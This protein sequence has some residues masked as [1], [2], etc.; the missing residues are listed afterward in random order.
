MLHWFRKARG[1]LA[2]DRL[3][4]GVE[5]GTIGGSKQQ[6]DAELRA[7]IRVRLSD[8]DNALD[9][10]RQ[11]INDI[12]AIEVIDDPLGMNHE[13]VPYEAL[14]VVGRRKLA[15]G[16]LEVLPR[17]FDPLSYRRVA[18]EVDHVSGSGRSSVLFGDLLETG[19]GGDA[20][21]I[22]V[23][24]GNGK[25]LIARRPGAL[26]TS[27]HRLPM[28][29]TRIALALV[30]DA[31]MLVTDIRLDGLPSIVVP[32]LDRPLALVVSAGSHG[33][34]AH[35][36]P[37]EEPGVVGKPARVIG[38]SIAG[39]SVE[40]NLGF[41]VFDATFDDPRIIVRIIPDQS[42]SRL[43]GARRPTVDCLE[44]L[45]VFLPQPGR[46]KGVEAVR[47]SLGSG[48]QLQGH[49]LDATNARVTLVGRRE[50]RVQLLK[51]RSKSFARRGPVPETGLKSERA[52]SL[53]PSAPRGWIAMT[54]T[55]GSPLGWIPL[56]LA[57]F[58][59]PAE[60]SVDQ[61]FPQL[62]RQAWVD[63]ED[64]GEQ[65]GGVF[66]DWLDHAVQILHQVPEEGG[67][68]TG[69]AR[70]CAETAPPGLTDMTLRSPDGRARIKRP[71][72]EETVLGDAQPFRFGPLWVRFHAAA[73]DGKGP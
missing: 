13:A 69:F 24:D 70:W 2:P 36:H 1:R 62:I 7:L 15:D 63:S 32:S 27:T 52:Q 16:L 23:V 60:G 56:R 17:Y 61:A 10:T 8:G 41:E 54:A 18:F 59:G 66:L 39:A 65:A 33:P 73:P 51:G 14:R 30:P 44:I 58:A 34:N 35:L 19:L 28:G 57:R 64:L 3:K 4:N 71:G 43:L 49:G 21:S 26:E 46:V 40:R 20:G 11:A 38:R 72:T 68:L 37:F 9:E 29:T 47:L 6:L 12:A 25:S 22:A 31:Q 50:R 55:P 5:V 67:R 48:N 42:F 45:G 53:D